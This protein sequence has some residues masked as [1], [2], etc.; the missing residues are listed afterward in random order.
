M[1]G[2]GRRTSEFE[3]SLSYRVC[4]KTAR[5]TPRNPVSK[6]QKDKKKKK[7]EKEKEKEKEKTDSTSLRFPSFLHGRRNFYYV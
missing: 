2:R 5:A 4:S 6:K 1:G 3:A 7:K